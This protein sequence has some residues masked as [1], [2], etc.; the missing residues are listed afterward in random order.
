[1]QRMEDSALL[2]ES[3]GVCSWTNRE[4]VRTGDLR[5]DILSVWDTYSHN[6]WA[7]LL[8]LQT[9]GEVESSE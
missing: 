9:K 5:L 1:M 4:A 3:P 8:A 6:D 7:I 2:D